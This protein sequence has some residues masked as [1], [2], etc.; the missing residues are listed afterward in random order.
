[1]AEPFEIEYVGRTLDEAASSVVD[2]LAAYAR[3]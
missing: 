3:P 2:E 1:M